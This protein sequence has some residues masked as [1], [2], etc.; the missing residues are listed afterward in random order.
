M[1]REVSSEQI[2]PNVSCHSSSFSSLKRPL[3]VFRWVSSMM[4]LGFHTDHPNSCLEC[5]REWH[6]RRWKTGTAAFEFVWKSWTKKVM[7]VRAGGG[8]CS[9]YLIMGRG[10]LCRVATF[11]GGGSAPYHDREYWKGSKFVGKD[12]EFILG[13]VEFEVFGT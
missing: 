12:Y 4:G 6:E 8:K 10:E 5:E 3:K 7:V 2:M 9:Q 11:P 1:T 13:M